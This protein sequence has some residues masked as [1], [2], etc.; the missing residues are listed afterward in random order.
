MVSGLAFLKSGQTEDGGIVYDPVKPESGAD[1]NSTAYTVQAI[2]AAG[3]DP[4]GAE[5][6][7]GGNTP[8]SFLLSLQLADGSFEW[9][10]GLGA[11]LLATAQ[12]IPALLRSPYPVVTGQVLSCA[13][14]SQD[15]SLR[16][17]PAAPK[18]LPPRRPARC[19]GHWVREPS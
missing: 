4:S 17:A 9:Q 11:N 8:V 7:V 15:R 3:Q 19:P 10:P 1:A 16:R 5:W 18:T 13:P 6:T 12:A 14:R 2:L